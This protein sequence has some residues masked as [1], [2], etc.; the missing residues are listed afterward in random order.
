MRTASEPLKARRIYLLLKDKIAS[1]ELA[2]GERLPG[3]FAL[4]EEHSVSR[5]TIR[6]ALD[7]LAGE[8]LIQ[9]K[10]GLGTFVHRPASKVRT[11]LADVSNVFA[12]LIEMGRTTDVRLLSFDYVNPSEQIRE[13]L[14]LAPDE[15]SQRSVRVRL[16][17]GVPFSYLIANVPERIG[18]NY[19]REDLARMP[20]LELIER[21]GLT[22]ASARQE[23]SAVL[24]SPDVAEALDIDVGMPLVALRRTVYGKDGQPMEH[25]QA[26][27][28]PDR[29]TLQMNLER[30]G[31]EGHRHW[32]PTAE[33]YR[34]ERPRRRPPVRKVGK[35]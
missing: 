9:K 17:D 14:Q 15:R 26:L 13:A 28:R 24:S 7:L 16:V 4:A 6:Q 21:S 22:S 25:L 19:S 34:R 32:S 23:I 29:Y 2:D 18:R 8:D 33:V 27:Y 5:V 31:D 1:G 35:S 12:H 3:E 11:V 10:S 30:T 20:L